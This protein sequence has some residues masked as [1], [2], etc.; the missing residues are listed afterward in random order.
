MARHVKRGDQ[1][2]ITS[3]NSKGQVGEI[4]SIDIEGD[5]VV[6]GGVLEGGGPESYRR[7]R[8][9]EHERLE[10][11]QVRAGLADDERLAHQRRFRGVLRGFGADWLGHRVKENENR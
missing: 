8:R 3:G 9:Q 11:T 10:V 4:L 7:E 5:R 1:V 6:V 2:I